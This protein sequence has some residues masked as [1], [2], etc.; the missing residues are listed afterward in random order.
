[1]FWENPTVGFQTLVN[2]PHNPPS[3]VAIFTTAAG[4]PVP[5]STAS[6]RKLVLVL[7]SY[8]EASPQSQV[9]LEV[10]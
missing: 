6:S 8:P 7:Y 10:G 9:L 3:L 1:M 5:C 4:E 2:L